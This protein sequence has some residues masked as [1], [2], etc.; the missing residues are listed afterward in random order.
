MQ[1]PSMP[2]VAARHG[3]PLDVMRVEAPVAAVKADTLE[4]LWKYWS[5]KTDLILHVCVCVLLSSYSTQE[6]EPSPP[7]TKYVALILKPSE[8]LRF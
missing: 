3:T 2:Y 8:Q 1:M 5:F 6:K 4:T 7:E